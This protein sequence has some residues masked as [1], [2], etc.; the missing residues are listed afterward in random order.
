MKMFVIIYIISIC[1]EW[2]KGGFIE[3]ICFVMKLNVIDLI[4][5]SLLWEIVCVGDQKCWV[6][7]FVLL[8]NDKL[9]ICFVISKYK[10]I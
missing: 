1:Y 7:I 5:I 2:V 3:I 8:G 6:C 10:G 4:N 9:G